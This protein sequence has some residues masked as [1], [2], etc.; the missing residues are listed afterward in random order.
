M[1]RRVHEEPLAFQRALLLT[2][3]SPRVLFHA[4]SM[5]ELEQCVPIMHALHK[6]VPHTEIFVS[7]TSPSGHSHARSLPEAACALY[8]PLDTKRNVSR[9][10]NVV[11][12]DA[13]VIDRYDV[14]PNFIAETHRRGV[15]IHLVNATMPSAAMNRFLR[16]WVRG[17]YRLLSTIS[18]VDPGD[19]TYLSELTGMKINTLPDTRIDRVLERISA[20]NDRILKLRRSDLITV[21]I[22]SSWPPD[23]DM[24]FQSIANINDSRLRLIIVP[25]EPTE[26]AVSTIERELPMTR[27]TDATQETR[28]H[29][30]VDTVGSLLSLYS[31]ADAAFIGGG[32]GAGVHSVTEPAVHGIPIAC[33]PRT[34]RSRDARALEAAGVL[35]RVTEPTEATAW[36]RTIVLDLDT[37]NKIGRYANEFFS[38]RSGSS[39]RYAQAIASSLNEQS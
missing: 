39:E 20:P 2:K 15:P 23:E 6:L 37:R 5:G 33:G 3:T 4:A 34:E 13:V 24:M 35:C 12:P 36:L 9:Y 7:S 1:K 11:Q 32:F 16:S 19:A 29:I 8:Q 38:Q 17:F 25:H 30:V 22:G 21:V 10:L 28:G 18:A 31:I 14:W 26:E 27:L